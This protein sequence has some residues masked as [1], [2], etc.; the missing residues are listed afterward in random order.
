MQG[1]CRRFGKNPRALGA[2]H[3]QAATARA[4]AGA[5]NFVD[6]RFDCQ[7]AGSR[8]YT[9]LVLMSTESS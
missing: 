4:V 7:R 8:A 5:R 2:E 9:E 1:I 3:T 6:L